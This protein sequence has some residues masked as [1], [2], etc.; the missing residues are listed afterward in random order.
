VI[1]EPDR[2]VEGLDVPCVV[3]NSDITKFWDYF[4]LDGDSLGRRFSKG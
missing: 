2:S 1:V 4:R 3:K